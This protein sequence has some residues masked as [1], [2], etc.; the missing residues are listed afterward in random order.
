MAKCFTTWTVLPHKPL[1]KLAENL[2]QVEGTMPGGEMHRVMVVA[3]RA[4][5][6]LV[7]HNGI[8]LEEPLM[9]E[10]EAFGT[11]RWLLVPNGFHR[12]D[13]FIWKQ[14]YPDLKVLCPAGARKRVAKV[15]AVSGDYDDYPPDA[16]VKLVHLEGFKRAEGVLEIISQ[17]GRSYVF[18][19][20]IM[21]KKKTG[22]VAGFFIGPTGKP[23]VPRFARWVWMKDKRSFRAHLE[24][25]AHAPDVRRIIVSHGR[26][27]D[28]NAG[29]VLAQI[30][31]DL[32]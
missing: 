32:G 4:D 15:V 2:W 11:P 20:A 7:I 27:I 14:R 19:D 16:H 8:A 24:R 12:Q 10:L 17:D 29:A 31:A 23:S 21:N 6:D 26:T 5:G 18:N 28:E 30:A 1:A 13:A 22:G 9:A 25:L 3:K